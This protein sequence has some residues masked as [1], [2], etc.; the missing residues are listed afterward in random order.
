MKTIDLTP[1]FETIK[2]VIQRE[3]R[4]FSVDVVT[5]VRPAGNGAVRYET[6][7][8]IWD[9]AEFFRGSTTNEALLGFL[10]KW[11]PRSRWVSMVVPPATVVVP[12]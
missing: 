1:V 10:E 11:D 8:E 2:L 12:E 5:W 4:A 6:T 9:G 3:N 7:I